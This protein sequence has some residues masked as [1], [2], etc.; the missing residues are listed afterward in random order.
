MDV[1]QAE[2]ATAMK[3]PVQRLTAIL[4]GKRAVTPDTALRLSQTLGCSVQF[5][6][7]FQ[8]DVELYDA[9]NKI[10]L[11]SLASVP[12]LNPSAAG[13]LATRARPC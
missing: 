13:A 4:N 8:H 7:G 11:R 1:T 10:D 2:L 12:R 6:L 9:I 3:M 5:W